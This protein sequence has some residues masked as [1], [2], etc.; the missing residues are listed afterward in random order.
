MALPTSPEMQAYVAQLFKAHMAEQEAIIR[1]LLERWVSE[2]EPVVVRT[3]DSF[4]DQ[5]KGLGIANDPTGMIVLA[6]PKWREPR[7]P[8]E[9]LRR[10]SRSN[11]FVF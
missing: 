8:F 5:V 9:L 1:G 6:N 11:Q 4:S 2:L 7:K 3:Y 10:A